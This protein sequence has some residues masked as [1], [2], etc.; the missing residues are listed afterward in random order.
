MIGGIPRHVVTMEPM[1]VPGWGNWTKLAV[2]LHRR[3][4]YRYIA[5]RV[6][7]KPAT[8]CFRVFSVDQLPLCRRPRT[9][10]TRHTDIAMLGRVVPGEG[11]GDLEAGDGQPPGRPLL[12]TSCVVATGGRNV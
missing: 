2:S 4:T 1:L 9:S 11:E 12:T 10:G 3:R 6:T 5:C 8:P 7:P